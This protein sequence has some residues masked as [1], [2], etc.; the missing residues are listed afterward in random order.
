[1]WGESKCPGI[2]QPAEHREL[3]SYPHLEKSE[4]WRLCLAPALDRGCWV[5]ETHAPRVCQEKADYLFSYSQHWSASSRPDVGHTGGELTDLGHR[6]VPIQD[7]SQGPKEAMLSPRA[8]NEVRSYVPAHQWL[9]VC[10]RPKGGGD[11]WRGRANVAEEALTL[12]ELEK[13]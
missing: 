2:L 7:G 10:P 1:M 11:K 13:F 12:S 5:K 6:P 3:G 8:R 9:P 4:G